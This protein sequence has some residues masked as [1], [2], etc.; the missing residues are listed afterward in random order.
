MR[1]AGEGQ[2]GFT[3]Q[4]PFSWIVKDTI[5]KFFSAVVESGRIPGWYND[6]FIQYFYIIF[7]ST[8]LAF[9]QYFMHFK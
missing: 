5:D 4:F 9:S 2:Q 7:I 1:K 3:M 8:Q 6:V